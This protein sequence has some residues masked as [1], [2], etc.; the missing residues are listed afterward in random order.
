ME[1][2]FLRLK[3]TSLNPLKILLFPVCLDNV[4]FFPFFFSEILIICK[5]L[6]AGV[7]SVL[8]KLHKLCS[9]L[10]FEHARVPHGAGAY[11]GEMDSR[12]SQLSRGNS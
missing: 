11:Q 10:I 3:G 4:N 8:R 7:V 9:R 12:C 5:T 6:C 1:N 2:A